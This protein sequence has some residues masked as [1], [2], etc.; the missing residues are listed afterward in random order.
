[1]LLLGK[2]ILYCPKGEA[3]EGRRFLRIIWVIEQDYWGGRGDA[4]GTGISI[5]EK[6]KMVEFHSRPARRGGDAGPRGGRKK[7]VRLA[8]GISIRSLLSAPFKK[9]G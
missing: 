7:E 5:K 8:S 3:S 6:G 2:T 1:M 9:K 4:K